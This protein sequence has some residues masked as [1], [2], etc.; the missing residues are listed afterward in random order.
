MFL[1]EG[2]HLD[3]IA[4]SVSKLQLQLTQ[5]RSQASTARQELPAFVRSILSFRKPRPLGG[6]SANGRGSGAA[7][8]G[9]HG[10]CE[11]GLRPKAY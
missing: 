2:N 7:V 11:S 3:D 1:N 9:L 10:Q 5:L 4:S 6:A 8:P